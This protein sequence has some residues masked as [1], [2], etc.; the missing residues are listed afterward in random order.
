MRS[1]GSGSGW[2]A[3]ALRA[4]HLALL[5]FAV[6]L[7]H[8]DRLAVQ[9]IATELDGL[10]P[11][12]RRQ[13]AFG[14]FRRTSAG[15]CAAILQPDEHSV[16]VLRQHLARIDDERLQRAFSA[17]VGVG[18]TKMSAATQPVRRDHGL[19]RGLSSRDNKRS[20]A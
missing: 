5:R 9:A 11:L 20:R 10:D 6:T 16:A 2:H 18:Q 4:W 3:K 1:N 7:D 19:W 17:A 14:F 13:S 12:R 8:A 15:L